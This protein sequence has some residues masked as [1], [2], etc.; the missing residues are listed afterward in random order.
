MILH[1]IQAI[2]EPG[3]ECLTLQPAFDC[4]G[5]PWLIALAQD[6][7]LFTNQQF[8]SPCLTPWSGLKRRRSAITMQS[9]LCPRPAS[10][11]ALPL[12]LVVSR[13]S[14]NHNLIFTR[15]GSLEFLTY[16]CLVLPW[17][18]GVAPSR[19]S[20]SR[21]IPFDPF[22]GPSYPVVCFLSLSA[23]VRCHVRFCTGIPCL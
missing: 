2:Q 21:R 16:S 9:M 5:A 11:S 1:T 6:L 13:L 10:L 19:L 22:Q 18:F 23:S 12:L 20:R 17:R 14:T 7:A 15:Q 3:T 8:R 4:L